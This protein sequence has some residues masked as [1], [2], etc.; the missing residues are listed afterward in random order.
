MGRPRRDPD[1]AGRREAHGV[2]DRD[3]TLLRTSSTLDEAPELLPARDS[4]PAPWLA[5][6]LVVTNE[7][8]AAGR[9]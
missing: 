2:S 4:V 3:E 8:W 9:P 6:G 1:P 7:P 5:G